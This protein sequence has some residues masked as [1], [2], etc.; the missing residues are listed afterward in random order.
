MTE[1]PNAELPENMDYIEQLIETQRER[2]ALAEVRE[3]IETLKR[4]TS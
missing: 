1:A 4:E 3:R 2:E